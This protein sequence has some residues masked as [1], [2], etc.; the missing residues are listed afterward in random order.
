MPISKPTYR[1]LVGALENVARLY[2][3]DNVA[4]NRVYRPSGCGVMV[5]MLDERARKIR[6]II[7]EASSMAKIT[8]EIN[9]ENDAFVKDESYEVAR[10]LYELADTID[11]DGVDAVANRKLRDV[12]GNSTGTVTVVR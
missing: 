10:I 3:R 2:D 4:S 12:D 1:E 11:I 9:L 7:E 6:E 5:F 8:I